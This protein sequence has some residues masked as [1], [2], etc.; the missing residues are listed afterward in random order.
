MSSDIAASALDLV[1]LNSTNVADQRRTL[2][3]ASPI[4]STQPPDL[5][6][7]LRSSRVRAWVP[8]HLIDS[9]NLK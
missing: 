6:K 1:C 9:L 8:Q 2:A 4:S 3:Q 5:K 7:I